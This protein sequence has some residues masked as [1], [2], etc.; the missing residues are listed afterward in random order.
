MKTAQAL[1]T[2]FTAQ[3]VLEKVDLGLFAKPK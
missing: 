1:A 3:R 2:M